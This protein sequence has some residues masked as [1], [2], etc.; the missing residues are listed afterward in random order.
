VCAQAMNPEGNNLEWL[1]EFEQ[2]ANEQLDQG[3]AC[4]Q[5]HPI[6]ENWLNDWLDSDFP[7]PRSS[8]SQ[9]LACLASEMLD[10]APESILDTLLEHCDEDEV[11]AWVQGVLLTGQAFQKGLDDGLLDDL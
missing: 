10:N 9:A 11:F 6:V 7:E 3:S 2:L 1:D 8:V 4:E 5:V